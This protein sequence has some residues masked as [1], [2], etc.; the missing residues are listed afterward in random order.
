[1]YSMYISSSG[2]IQVSFELG[3]ERMV[4]STGGWGMV[5]QLCKS[6]LTT[7]SVERRPLTVHAYIIHTYIIYTYH[8]Y[9][10][11][12]YIYTYIM[13]VLAAKSAVVSVFS[14]ICTSLSLAVVD[15]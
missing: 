5:G 7:S 15:Q 3:G 12:C 10:Y 9:I 4:P 11:I 2:D 1:M 13:H 6:T 8:T 14:R